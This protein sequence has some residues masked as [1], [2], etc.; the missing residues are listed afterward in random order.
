MV[1]EGSSDGGITWTALAD[2]YDATYNNDWLN[3]YSAQQAGSPDLFVSH[4]IDLLDTFSPG[5]EVLIRFRLYSDSFV[6]GWG[7]TID[8][9]LIQESTTTSVPGGADLPAAFSLH[10]NYPNPFNP[11]TTIT[12]D[13]PQ[14]T[15]VEL[16]VY[17]VAG[18]LVRTLLHQQEQAAGTYA[19]TWDG[20]NDAG[21]T[22]ASGMYLYRISTSA[23][24]NET[25]RMVLIK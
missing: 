20:R 12:Y 3:A 15:D 25:R 5:D 13:L 11:S 17:D 21:Q 18:R 9:L 4:Q 8:N 22:V 16:S 7:W 23:G 1:V 19:L 2:G 14:H 6:N 24:F 10:A